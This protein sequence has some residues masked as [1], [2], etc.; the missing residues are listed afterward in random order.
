MFEIKDIKDY[1]NRLLNKNDN[2]TYLNLIFAKNHKYNEKDK[3]LEKSDEKIK[4]I[5]NSVLEYELF[6]FLKLNYFRCNLR[7]MLTSWFLFCF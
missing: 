3:A 2:W 1:I 5:I 7:F 6:K 4:Y